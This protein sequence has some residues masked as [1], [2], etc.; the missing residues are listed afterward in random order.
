MPTQDEIK[1]IIAKLPD[2]DNPPP[3]TR[4]A[5]GPST[6][7][8]ERPRPGA[9]LKGK[10]TGPVWPD[11]AAL[12]DQLLSAGPDAVGILTDLVPEQDPGPAYK[13]RYFLHGL[14]TY[15]CRP[16]KAAPR[17]LVVDA[18]ISRLSSPTPHTRL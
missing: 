1:A 4:P 9:P 15:V 18:L 10:L 17:K 13:P 12:Y 5:T 8:V 14:A 7:Q 2:L 3:R 11:A 16:D 6:R